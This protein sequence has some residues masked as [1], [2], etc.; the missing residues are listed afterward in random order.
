V[1]VDP[2]AYIPPAE[3]IPGYEAPQAAQGPDF[4]AWLTQQIQSTS[5]K[6][7]ASDTLRQRLALGEVDNLHQMMIAMEEAKLSFQLLVQVRNKLL[8][9]YQDIMRM[10]V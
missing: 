9:A 5:D 2:V 8:D 7:N 6:I 10:Q 3:E 1:N 4:G